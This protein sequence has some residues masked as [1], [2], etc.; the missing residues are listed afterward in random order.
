MSSSDIPR[1]AFPSTRAA[2]STEAHPAP[3]KNEPLLQRSSP[4]RRQLLGAMGALSRADNKMYLFPATA[5]QVPLKAWA[6][7][8]TH[9][10]LAG[11]LSRLFS[12]QRTQASRR[13]G[14]ARAEGGK[15]P[16]V[17]PAAAACPPTPGGALQSGVLIF[18]GWLAGSVWLLIASLRK[19]RAP[20][21]AQGARP[22]RPLAFLSPL[23]ATF[24]TTTHTHTKTFAYRTKKLNFVRTAKKKTKV[25]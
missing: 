18:G 22:A 25:V 16:S 6:E 13:G 12:E 4:I 11:H 20:G 3:A 24:S 8:Q 15:P 23:S 10:A 21:A 17:E 14:D 19:R 1:W 5:D 9:D 7:A 2:F